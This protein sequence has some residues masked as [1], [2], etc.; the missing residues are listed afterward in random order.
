MPKANT[1]PAGRRRRRKFL[2]RAKGFVG[3][4][5]KLYRTARE[6]VQRALMFATRDRRDRKGVFRRLW[7][8]RISAG[9]D[10]NGITYSRLIGGLKKANV[11]IDRKILADLAHSEK[12]VFSRLVDIAREK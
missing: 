1:V 3:G 9:C 5:R 10:A 12:K 2:K 11:V 8:T 4:R 6:T 7:I